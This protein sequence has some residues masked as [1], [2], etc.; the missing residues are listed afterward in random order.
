MTYCNLLFLCI[1]LHRSYDLSIFLTD[2]C[3]PSSTPWPCSVLN[4]DCYRFIIW[5]VDSPLTP[6]FGFRNTPSWHLPASELLHNNLFFCL[7]CLEPPSLNASHSSHTSLKSLPIC[8]LY[9]HSCQILKVSPPLNS[10][11]RFHP[12]VSSTL[13][14]IVI[15][16]FAKH[17][18][19]LFIMNLFTY[20]TSIYQLP[21]MYKT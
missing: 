15:W 21:T 18:G 14:T 8:H 11:L 10:Q 2:D 12:Y 1:Q 3:P 19:L 6:L 20:S 7:L 16:P 9:P 13:H 4:L 17:L 5:Y